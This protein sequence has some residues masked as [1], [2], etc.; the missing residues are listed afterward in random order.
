MHTVRVEFGRPTKAPILAGT[1][2]RNT[3][4]DKIGIVFAEGIPENL[5]VVYLNDGWDRVEQVEKKLVP[6]VSGTKIILEVE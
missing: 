6:V 4:S 2:V 1:L 5:I 3:E